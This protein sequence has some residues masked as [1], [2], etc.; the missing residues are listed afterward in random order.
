VSLITRRDTTRHDSFFAA[1]KS[2]RLTCM[3]LGVRLHACTGLMGGRYERALFAMDQARHPEFNYTGVSCRMS[4]SVDA[5]RCIL[6][7]SCD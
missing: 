5:N 2:W 1:L 6:P 7:L 4:Y 3:S